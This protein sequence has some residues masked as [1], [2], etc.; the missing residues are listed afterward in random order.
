MDSCEYLES[1][2]IQPR[3]PPSIRSSDYDTGLTDPYLYYLTRRLGLMPSLRWS[4]ALQQGTFFHHLFAMVDDPDIYHRYEKMVKARL[5]ELTQICESTGIKGEQRAAILHEEHKNAA[6]AQAWF[7]ATEEVTCPRTS[8]G[9]AITFQNWL[10]QYRI[11]GRETRLSYRLDRYRIPLVAQYDLLTYHASSDTLWIVDAKT[12]DDPPKIRLSTTLHEFQTQHYMIT[13]HRNF[14]AVRDR[15]GLPRSTRFAG[16]VHVAIWK[17]SIRFGMKDRDWVWKSEGKQKHFSGRLLSNAEESDPWLAEWWH[18][19]E[20]DAMVGSFVGTFSACHDALWKATGKKPGKVYSGE[21][22]LQ[23]YIKRLLECYL[24]EGEYADK[25]EDRLDEPPVNWISTPATW[26]D[27]EDWL[28]E[29]QS[30]VRLIHDL[31]T[32]PP[33]PD[34]FHRNMP[35]CRRWGKHT[36]HAPF[37]L[38]PVKDWPEIVRRNHFVIFHRDEELPSEPFTFTPVQE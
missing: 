28:T 4:K 24:G 33:W 22:R 16:M 19:D 34:Q 31:A 25:H 2:G 14:D 30:R 20:P 1:K 38:N 10:R 23:N 9:E 36:D 18:N 11:V 29:Y 3:I 32:C 8:G 15:L 37:Y 7:Q 26:C 35:A 27:D 5:K 6:E 17:P 21:P 13:M 12:T